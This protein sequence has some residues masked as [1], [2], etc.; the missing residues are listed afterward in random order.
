[1]AKF[2]VIVP[3]AGKA[4][5]FGGEEKKA[6]AKL[7]GR[8]IF[9][10]SI[11]HFVNR[12]DVCQTILA[13][14]REDV[15]QVKS[16][17]GVNLGFMGATLVEGGARRR[18][19]VA[20][21]LKVVSDKADY[22]AVH[23]AARPCVTADMIDAVF[24]EAQK[25]G[26]AI[27]AAPLTGTIKRVG[28]SKVVDET[29]PRT[30]LYEAQTPQVF[31]KNVLLEAY[32]RCE[33]TEE[34]ITDDAQVVERAGHPVSVVVSDLTNLKITT[35]ADMTLAAAIIKARPARRVARFGAFE[36]AQW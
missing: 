33:G 2:C 12:E 20:A 10:R 23:D 15:D 28:Q 14:A 11:E 36:E 27:L 34:E 21:A 3:A 24:A 35:R 8:P 26:A 18:D 5:R 4:E 1:M 17:Y 16:S 6:F 30:G 7:D 32:A 19:T 29:M 25:S 9:I 22:I 13:V 31:R